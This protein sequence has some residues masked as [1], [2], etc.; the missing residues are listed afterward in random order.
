MTY[1][2][3]PLRILLKI[4]N[5]YLKPTNKYY[6]HLERGKQIKYLYLPE[7]EGR[8]HNADMIL[9]EGAIKVRYEVFA[10][11]RFKHYNYEIPKKLIFFFILHSSLFIYCCIQQKKNQTCHDICVSPKSYH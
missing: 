1:S 9:R 11:G 5:I 2:A 8:R 6:T 4:L 7:N 3:T 10:L